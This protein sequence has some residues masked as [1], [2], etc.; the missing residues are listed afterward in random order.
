MPTVKKLATE[1]VG[2]ADGVQFPKQ[3]HK[4]TNHTTL[5]TGVNPGKHGVLSNDYWGRAE[6][7]EE[8]PLIPDPILNKDEMVKDRRSM[9]W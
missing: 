8:F 7:R 6:W 5:V 1:A 9:M 4:W 3:N 2:E